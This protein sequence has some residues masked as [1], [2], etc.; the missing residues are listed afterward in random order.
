MSIERVAA[1]T[2]SNADLTMRVADQMRRVKTQILDVTHLRVQ[3][4]NAQYKLDRFN[5]SNAHSK[6]TPDKRTQASRTKLQE[7]LTKLQDKLAKEQAKLATDQ[8]SIVKM[9]AKLAKAQVTLANEQAKLVNAQNPPPKNHQHHKNV[10]SNLAKYQSMLKLAQHNRTT[11]QY[12]LMDVQD[13]FMDDYDSVD[14]QYANEQYANEQ[15]A[16]EQYA[17]DQFT[18]DDDQFTDDDE[19]FTD[20]DHH[21]QFYTSDK[22]IDSLILTPR[23]QITV[24]FNCV[25]FIEPAEVTLTITPIDDAVVVQRTVLEYHR[26]VTAETNEPPKDVKTVDEL[27]KWLA[28]RTCRCG[29]YHYNLDNQPKIRRA[30]RDWLE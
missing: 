14:E 6:A 27:E 17:N 26:D 20:D 12:E 7:K 5:R 13:R 10:L 30:V 11:A 3:L 4:A 9:Q 22:F 21:A 2:Q 8:E 28:D 16:N 25:M 24:T 1:Q 19:Q 15:Y 18:A 23:K 29:R